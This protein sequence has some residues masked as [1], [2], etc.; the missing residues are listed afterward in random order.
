MQQSEEFDLKSWVWLD[1]DKLKL[2]MQWWMLD[3][4]SEHLRLLHN[5]CVIRSRQAR[6]ADNTCLN[7]DITGSNLAGVK[8]NRV[9]DQK[10]WNGRTIEWC[11]CIHNGR[12]RRTV[13]KYTDREIPIV[14]PVSGVAPNKNLYCWRVFTIHCSYFESVEQ[15]ARH[16]LGA[17]R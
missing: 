2:R 10:R 15:W 7:V 17:D 1:R 16:F 11:I 8:C 14:I 3:G 9:N 12:S 6:R 5:I 13:H 4:T